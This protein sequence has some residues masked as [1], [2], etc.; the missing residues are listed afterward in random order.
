MSWSWSPVQTWTGGG[1]GAGP[2]PEPPE[3]APAVGVPAAGVPAA[4][5]GTLGFGSAVIVGDVALPVKLLA[6]RCESTRRRTRVGLFS[7]MERRRESG[8][9]T[10]I[11]LPVASVF[12]AKTA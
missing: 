7:A 2:P 4:G 10:L 11:S 5:A 9:T 8:T 1:K 6:K 3:G 12:F